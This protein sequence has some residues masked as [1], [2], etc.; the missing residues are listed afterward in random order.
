[1]LWCIA[2]KHL[3]IASTHR[4]YFIHLV[5]SYSALFIYLLHIVVSVSIVF[6]TYKAVL[7]IC[8][9]K[10]GTLAQFIIAFSV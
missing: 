8:L 1:M 9:S 10:Y 7:L 4:P 2:G 6:L 3:L 5:Y